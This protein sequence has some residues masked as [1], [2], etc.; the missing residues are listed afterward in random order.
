MEV[1]SRVPGKIVELKVKVGDSVKMKDVVA[2]MEAMKMKQPIPAPLDG[3]VKEIRVNVGD[4]VD[5]GNVI[6]IIE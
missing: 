2:V 4:R 3:T 6:L 1:K 5:P